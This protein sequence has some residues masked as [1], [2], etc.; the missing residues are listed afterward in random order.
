VVGIPEQHAEEALG[1]LASIRLGN[2]QGNPA[3]AVALP[4]A[5]ASLAAPSPADKAPVVPAARGD[6]RSARPRAGTVPTPAPEAAPPAQPPKVRVV[7]VSVTSPAAPTS[8]PDEDRERARRAL[9]QGQTTFVSAAR[10]WRQPEPEPDSRR[11]AGAM[12]VSLGVVL[13]LAA[14][15][16]F[17]AAGA[18]V[19][20]A[21]YAAVVLSVQDRGVLRDRERWTAGLWAAAAS[22]AAAAGVWLVVAAAS[23]GL[24]VAGSAVLAL[25]A[26]PPAQDRDPQGR[27]ASSA[28]SLSPQGSTP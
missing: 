12:L 25:S 4:V 3:A 24:S 19:G 15:F 8:A 11:P 14:A 20:A 26:A 10:S 21:G 18:L 5:Q 17:V 6:K 27:G 13:G 23:V 7:Y 1:H 9:V 28:A 16:P 2:A 22:G